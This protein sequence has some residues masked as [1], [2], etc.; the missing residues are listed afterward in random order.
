M[1]RRTAMNSGQNKE[2]AC[3]TVWRDRKINRTYSQVTK[4][5]GL[6]SKLLAI[7]LMAILAYSILAIIIKTR[8][9]IYIYIYIYI[10]MIYR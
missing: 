8:L 5:F 10:Y 1:T 9:Y 3:V 2:L 6:F 4:C 7:G